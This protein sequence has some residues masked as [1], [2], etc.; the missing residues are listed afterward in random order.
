MFSFKISAEIEHDTGKEVNDERETYCKE[1]RID[2]K[3]AYFIDRNVETLAYVGTNAEWV[4]FK[5]SDY[6]LQHI[7]SF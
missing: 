1:W 6:P 7:K 3:Q 5:K 2:K 4:S